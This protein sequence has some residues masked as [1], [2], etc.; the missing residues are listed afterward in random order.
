VNIN[1]NVAVSTIDYEHC[2]LLQLK[3]PSNTM[4]V[5]GMDNFRRGLHSYL[6]AVAKTSLCVF[7]TELKH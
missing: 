6:R 5:G 2:W 1:G 4:N 3:T 7:L